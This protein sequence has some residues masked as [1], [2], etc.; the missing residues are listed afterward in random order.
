MIFVGSGSLPKVPDDVVG[1]RHSETVRAPVVRTAGSQDSWAAWVGD[2]RSLYGDDSRNQRRSQLG[3]PRAFRVHIVAYAT[4]YPWTL[5][6]GA[7]APNPRAIGP[8]HPYQLVGANPVARAGGRS[9]RPDLWVR[10]QQVLSSNLSVG[11]ICY[12]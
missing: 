5:V 4:T 2:S 12:A 8:Y 1:D 10:K 6:G 7:D 3:H 11:S 9:G